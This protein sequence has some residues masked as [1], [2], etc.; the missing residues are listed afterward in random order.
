MLDNDAYRV[1]EMKPTISSVQR[2]EK[3]N[4]LCFLSISQLW[5][6][7]QPCAPPTPR[8]CVTVRTQAA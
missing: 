6:R 2:A 5:R 4:G 3:V 7:G 8:V 1:I